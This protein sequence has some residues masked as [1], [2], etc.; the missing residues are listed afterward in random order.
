MCHLCQ[1][2]WVPDAFGRPLHNSWCT[3]QISMNNYVKALTKSIHYHIRT[4]QLIG[5]SI[6]EDMAKIAACALFGSR[7]FCFIWHRSEKHLHTT[8]STKPP[9]TCRHKFLS[10]QFTYASPTALLAPHGIP[11]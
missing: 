11:C 9:S 10:I 2:C 7:K 1:R 3:Q 8:E 6:S 5:S 4:I